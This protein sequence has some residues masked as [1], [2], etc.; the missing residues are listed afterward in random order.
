[1]ID[2]ILEFCPR[3][4][5][6]NFSST[7]AALNDDPSPSPCGLLTRTGLFLSLQISRRRKNVLKY[8]A[9]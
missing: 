6:S 4:S 9:K 2:T 1:M 5:E 8:E 3:S 7:S